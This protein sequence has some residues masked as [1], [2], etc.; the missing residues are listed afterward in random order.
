MSF[1]VILFQTRLEIKKALS[2]DPSV[3]DYDAVYD[4][5]QE[6]RKSAQEA[7]Q[8][9][10][11]QPK[12]IINLLK[13]AEQRKRDFERMLERKAQREREQEGG[14]FDDKEAFVTEAFRRKMKQLAEDEERER[15]QAELDG[16]V[17][18]LEM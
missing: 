17:F 12:Y 16:M 9:K 13:T 18:K 6:K 10:S 15:K 14:M 1:I 3:Y 7:K 11:R 5:M 4:S 2:E 8:D